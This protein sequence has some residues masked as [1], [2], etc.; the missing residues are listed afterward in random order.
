MCV[1]IEY[2]K[3]W[4]ID[5][6]LS[7][8]ATS[9]DVIL[10]NLSEKNAPAVPLHQRQDGRTAELLTYRVLDDAARKFMLEKKMSQEYCKAVE[11]VPSKE[12][13]PSE[14]SD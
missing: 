3:H 9:L 7:K 11:R 13:R 14:R 2:Q 4:G 1:V 5:A 6:R 12:S 8:C 10:T